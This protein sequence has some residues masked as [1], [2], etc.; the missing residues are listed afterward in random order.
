[1]SLN[2]ASLEN[3]L[4]RKLSKTS[5]LMSKTE[6]E[7]RAI[8]VVREASQHLDTGVDTKKSQPQ[9]PSGLKLNKNGSAK[10]REETVVQD[11]RREI[12]Q[13]TVRGLELN[14]EVA[15][16]EVLQTFEEALAPEAI[17]DHLQAVSWCFQD[18]EPQAAIDAALKKLLD[19]GKVKE[20]K[21]HYR[22]AV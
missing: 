4:K 8:E 17:V 19:K 15:V 16:V 10:S 5:D 13:E 3:S 22:T 11:E 18:G 20:I 6:E 1:M 14:D 9:A 7:L 2:L 21:G 12:L